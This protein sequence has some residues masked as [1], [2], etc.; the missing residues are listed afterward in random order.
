MGA[1]CYVDESHTSSHRNR[2]LSES[3][4]VS[5]QGPKRTDYVGSSTSSQK[6]RRSPHA[7]SSQSAIGSQD[8]ALSR[9]GGYQAD[10]QSSSID[11]FRGNYGKFSLARS[12][13]ISM[14]RLEL[15]VLQDDD[16]PL[17]RVY[18]CEQIE[19]SDIVVDA[20]GLDCDDELCLAKNEIS[21]DFS[22]LLKVS[23]KAHVKV[24][25]TWTRGIE[26]FVSA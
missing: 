15:H 9:K 10:V 17:C 20:E 19:E 23:G 6:L 18:H 5:S 13:I 2:S 4:V 8:M 22:I 24:Y 25:C 26:V 12:E 3:K 11:S 1:F 16:V 21:E 7:V 14:G